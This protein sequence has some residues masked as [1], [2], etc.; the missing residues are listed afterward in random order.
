MSAATEPAA[1][2][3]RSPAGALRERGNWRSSRA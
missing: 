3:A 1:R 2:A